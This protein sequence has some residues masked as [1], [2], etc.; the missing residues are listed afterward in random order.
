MTANHGAVNIAV[1][2]PNHSLLFYWATNATATWHP[3]TVASGANNSAGPSI[4][5]NASFANIADVNSA[6]DL[7]F[8]WATDGTATWHAEAVPG[9][10]TGP[11][12]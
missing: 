6:G 1:Q 11:H 7:M 10:G 3:E 9:N 5:S 8:Y 2:G 12:A 4:T